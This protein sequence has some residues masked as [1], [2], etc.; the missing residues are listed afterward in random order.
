MYLCKYYVI[1][2]LDIFLLCIRAYIERTI[3][4]ILY[5]CILLSSSYNTVIQLVIFLVVV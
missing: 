5:N 1:C 2:I 3:Q 4:C